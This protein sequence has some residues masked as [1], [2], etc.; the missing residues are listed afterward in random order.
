[1]SLQTVKFSGTTFTDGSETDSVRSTIKFCLDWIRGNMNLNA[2]E[3]SLTQDDSYLV[4]NTRPV[5]RFEMEKL[6]SD[7][8]VEVKDGV[9]DFGE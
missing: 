7:L 1:M 4:D 6:A 3:M 8:K 5:A 2:F 9:W